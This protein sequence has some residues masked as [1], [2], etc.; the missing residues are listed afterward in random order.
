MDFS[1]HIVVA[2]FRARNLLVIF[3][4]LANVNVISVPYQNQKEFQRGFK[5]GDGH[6]N[7]NERKMSQCMLPAKYSRKKNPVPAVVIIQCSETERDEKCLCAHIVCISIKNN[8]S[9]TQHGNTFLLS[10]H[11]Q[12]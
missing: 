4:Q 12:S 2:S 10:V 3:S 9:L 6:Y 5:T 8:P 7:Y 11:L 1:I